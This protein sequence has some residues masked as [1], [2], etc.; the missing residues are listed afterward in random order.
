MKTSI[1][2]FLIVIQGIFCGDFLREDF[3]NLQNW[4]ELTFPKI[5]DHSQYSIESRD[6]ESYLKTFTSNSASGLIYKEQFDVY[7]YPELEWRWKVSNTFSK[8]NALEKSGDD[9]PLRIYV[10]FEYDPDESGFFESVVY[11]SARLIYGEYPPH[12]SLNYI[13]ANKAQ[14][15]RI[16]PNSYTD[17]AQ[18]IVLQEGEDNLGIWVTESMNMLDDYREAFGEDPPSTTTIAIMAD[19]D[20][21]G[22]SAT[23]YVDYFLVRTVT[24]DEGVYK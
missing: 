7:K 8:G 23:A 10:I 22:E 24:K 2:I 19:S 11:E 4:T 16:I 12:S 21:T 20:N 5:E 3:N 14:S 6:A 17:K 1:L 18:M 9:Y 13:W 15:K